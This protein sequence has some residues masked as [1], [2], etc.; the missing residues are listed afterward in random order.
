MSIK[1]RDPEESKQVIEPFIACLG[2]E[3]LNRAGSAP[4]ELFRVVENAADDLAHIG[5]KVTDARSEVDMKVG[6]L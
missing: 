6:R 1:V 3:G 2:E 5:P 4:L